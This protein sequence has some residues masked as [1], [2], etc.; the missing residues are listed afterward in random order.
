MDFL[1]TND[2]GR[3]CVV[4]EDQIIQS[5]MFFCWPYEAR[6]GDPARAAQWAGQA[7]ER[8]VAQGLPCREQ[9]GKRYFDFAQVMNF[10]RWA[11]VVNGD[12]AYLEASVGVWRRS[13]AESTPAD[14]PAGRGTAVHSPARFLVRLRRE[15]DLRD[16]VP[17]SLVRLR[18]PAPFED[19]TQGEVVVECIEPA[20]GRGR[21]S[22]APGRVELR[23]IVPERPSLVSVEVRIAFT[24]FCQSFEVD[25]ARLEGWDTSSSEYR[26]YTRPSEG[27]IQV[28]ETIR[29][30]ADEL[31]GPVRNPW[32]MVGAF[33]AFFFRR[34]KS[35]C[36]HHEELGTADPLAS[37]VRRGWFD[38]FTG[39]A[40]L[41]GLCRARGIP[42][43]LVSGVLLHP[44]PAYHYWT[45][46]FLPPYGWVP[47][48]LGSW[49]LAAGR[50][51]DVA[52]SGLFRGRLDY[53]MKT[54]CLPRLMLGNP[55]VRFPTAW[56]LLMRLTEEDTETSYYALESSRRLFCDRL[57][58]LRLPAHDETSG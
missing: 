12:P 24:A 51:D 5:L 39:S 22:V 6:F 32:E 16:S 33:W 8:W 57:R 40:L 3:Y 52:W 46:V 55:G 27:L 45:E 43:R 44:F 21:V 47:L 23:W 15:F 28:T 53:R 37:L 20:D 19:S 1:G 29:Q 2:D 25:P 42:A 31:A 4:A 49:E 17:G 38:C 41:V 35:G 18:V 58:V 10:L 13:L 50:I 56:Y 11:G 48:D 30:L 9:G 26:L 36:M 34:M 14:W 7:L 54:Q